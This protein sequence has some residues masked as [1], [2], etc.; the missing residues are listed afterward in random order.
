MKKLLLSFCLLCAFAAVSF[1]ETPI[2]LSLW[3]K[4]AIPNDDSVC[5]L[6][7]GLG[8]YMNR[9]VGVR[10]YCLFQN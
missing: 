10:E 1:A 9:L 2:K 4:I 7:I 6:E 3:E 5:G 8:T